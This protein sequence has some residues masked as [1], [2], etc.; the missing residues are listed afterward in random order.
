[1]MYIHMGGDDGDGHV[2]ILVPLLCRSILWG[3]CSHHHTTVVI[4]AIIDIVMTAGTTRSMDPGG[5]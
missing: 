3:C 2:S 5:S 4:P 1:M